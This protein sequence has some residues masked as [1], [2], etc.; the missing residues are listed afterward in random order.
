MGLIN[1]AETWTLS[2]GMDVPGAVPVPS[3]TL[4]ENVSRFIS[5]VQIPTNVL[6]EAMYFIYWFKYTTRYEGVS[7][8]FRACSA[9]WSTFDII[10]VAL[11][12]INKCKCSRC[13]F[14]AHALISSAALEEEIQ[15][16]STRTLLRNMTGRKFPN[17]SGRPREFKFTEKGLEELN[18]KI[19]AISVYLKNCPPSQEEEFLW[20]S[21]G[22]LAGSDLDLPSTSHP[23]VLSTGD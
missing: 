7:A 20:S 19:D 3:K 6:R 13:V 14:P 4:A 2:M 10:L 18:L 15:T 12:V 8:R 21:R 5:V 17:M 22:S 11:C 9:S 23:S 16:T 1:R